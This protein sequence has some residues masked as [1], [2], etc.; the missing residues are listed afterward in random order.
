[1]FNSLISLGNRL[2]ESVTETRI[3]FVLTAALS[4]RRDTSFVEIT[5][6]P[7]ALP[8]TSLTKEM[9]E[10]S[11]KRELP[12]AAFRTPD[13]YTVPADLIDLI[14]EHLALLDALGSVRVIWLRLSRPYGF[15]GLIP[16]EAQLVEGL[17][18]P[19]LRLPDFPARAAERTDVLENVIIV[20]PPGDHTLKAEIIEQLTTLSNAILSGTSRTDTRIHIFSTVDWY[21]ELSNFSTN[22]CVH[23]ADPA[24]AQANTEQRTSSGMSLWTDWILDTL[25]GRGIDAVHLIGRATMDEIEG[26]YVIS[27]TPFA[28]NGARP[29]FEIDLESIALLLNR[30][31]AWSISFMPACA[32]CRDSV[33]YVADAFAHGWQGSVLFIGA[34]HKADSEAINLATKLLYSVSAS[35]APRFN[36]GFL[37]CHPSFLNNKQSMQYAALTPL[38]AEQALLLAAR[39]PVTERAVSWITKALPGVTQ[40]NQSAPPAWLSST[41]RFLESEAFDNVRRNAKDILMSHR[42]ELSSIAESGAKL[43][44]ETENVLEQIRSVVEHYRVNLHKEDDNG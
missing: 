15:L 2:M 8:G 43:K 19:V 18:R 26:R 14:E 35:A 37:Y 27:G 42:S 1:M 28:T 13:G 31:G 17:Q 38:L 20:D 36:D 7:E 30:A 23:L 4:F 25:G 12:L 29:D 22:N 10:L 11:Q 39:A 32:E 41:Q 5:L 40:V 9:L 33:A 44:S 34:N 24:M 16:W 21:P 3:T 6:G